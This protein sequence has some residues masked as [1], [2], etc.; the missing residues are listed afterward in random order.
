MRFFN[1]FNTPTNNGN[2]Q[3]QVKNTVFFRCF[4]KNFSPPFLSQKNLSDLHCKML[5]TQLGKYSGEST[6][7]L[8]F[9]HL[10][11]WVHPLQREGT[12]VDKEI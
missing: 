4:T 5:P 1:A 3:E 7:H 6:L 11:D 8:E 12:Q 10:L 9:T 2:L